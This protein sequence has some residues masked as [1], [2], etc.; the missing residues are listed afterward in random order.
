MPIGRFYI[1]EEHKRTT[2]ALHAVY[3]HNSDGSLLR[4]FDVDRQL[5]YMVVL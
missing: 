4:H 3:V 1:R 5:V 2:F